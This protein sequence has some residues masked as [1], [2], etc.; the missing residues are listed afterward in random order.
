MSHLEDGTVGRAVTVSAQSLAGTMSVGGTRQAAIEKLSVY[1]LK[2]FGA[3]NVKVIEEVVKAA[4]PS[5]SSG[6]AQRKIST[7]KLEEI[8]LEIM[9]RLK[10]KKSVSGMDG[11]RQPATT[12]PSTGTRL[13]LSEV[14]SSRIRADK[15]AQTRGNTAAATRQ[16]GEQD[17]QPGPS[18]STRHAVTQPPKAA[19]APGWVGVPASIAE[20]ILSAT[21]DGGPQAN[22]RVW[23]GDI[24]GM[25]ERPW[26]VPPGDIP[27]PV[28]GRKLP[29]DGWDVVQDIDRKMYED[30][31]KKK[32]EVEA[33]KRE[34]YKK[35][36]EGQTREI[37]AMRE[38][39]RE[40]KRR[41]MVGSSGT[42]ESAADIYTLAFRFPSQQP[43]FSL[44][45]TGEIQHMYG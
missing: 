33:G 42:E 24:E 21:T 10:R 28:I 36:L 26:F 9:K 32:A 37:E 4:V 17:H 43:V 16:L 3:N 45:F 22:R 14:L 39:R 13:R 7:E 30:S 11:R 19:G 12:R 15:T 23:P 1:M 6:S 31:E 2:K 18:S 40:Q 41:D 20:S 34:K 8:E 29:V 38:E 27:K 44:S 25:V 5:E 35:G